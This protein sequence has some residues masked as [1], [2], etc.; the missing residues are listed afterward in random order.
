MK[1]RKE[2]E[3]SL[4]HDHRQR[5]PLILHQLQRPPH[6]SDI[7]TGKH[8][9]CRTGAQEP[10]TDEPDVCRFVAASTA[11]D[12]GDAV[13]WDLTECDDAVL[14]VEVEPGVALCEAE[15]RLGHGVGWCVDDVFVHDA[16]G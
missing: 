6:L 2:G 1:Q 9:P 13:L 8:I 10:G 14:R 15:E 5:P 11:G 7:R 16:V 4:S 3:D 12:E